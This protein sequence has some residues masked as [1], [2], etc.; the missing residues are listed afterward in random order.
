MGTYFLYYWEVNLTYINQC[1]IEELSQICAYAEWEPPTRPLF[2]FVF[3]FQIER[4]KICV[5]IQC[6][7]PTV[8]RKIQ[9]ILV[10]S[11]F[12]LFQ[13]LVQSHSTTLDLTSPERTWS[14]YK[15]P[16]N[17]LFKSFPKPSL[18]ERLPFVKAVTPRHYSKPTKIISPRLE[19]LRFIKRRKLRPVITSQ[20]YTWTLL[21]VTAYKKLPYID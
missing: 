11:L 5:P 13:N 19:A 14:L 8:N 7:F 6:Y 9:V 1:Y 3:L 20:R 17:S 21:D 18:I 16:S 10:Q 2:Y 4:L 15:K 12:R